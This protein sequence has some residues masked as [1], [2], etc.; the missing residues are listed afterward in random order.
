M[1][2]V[3]RLLATCPT[4][5]YLLITQPGLN[6]K[7]LQQ[8]SRQSAITT[9]LKKIFSDDRV[10][11]RYSVSELIGQISSDN[12]FAYI[13]AACNKA[14]QDVNIQEQR[15]APMPAAGT[16][17]SSEDDTLADKLGSATGAQSFTIL[18]LPTPREPIYEAEFSEP[19]RMDL[20]RNIDAREVRRDSN[21]SEWNK[22]PL[23]EKYQFFTPGKSTKS[24]PAAI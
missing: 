17:R 4:E 16:A 13:D 3:K 2:T 15:L 12:L 10:K 22:L 21:D 23:F 18:L 7:D 20:R 9:Q 14:G 8:T 24:L 11:G 6:I 1:D 5:N 19:V